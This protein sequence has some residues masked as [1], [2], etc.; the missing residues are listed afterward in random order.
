MERNKEKL[1]EEAKGGKTEAEVRR[2]SLRKG[3]HR[4]S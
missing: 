4:Q 1:E 3:S 2:D